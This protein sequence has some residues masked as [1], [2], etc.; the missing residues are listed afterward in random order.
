MGEISLCVTVSKATM[1][2]LKLTSM[3]VSI[4]GALSHA[5][6][7]LQKYLNTDSCTYL[8]LIPSSTYHICNFGDK[9][10]KLLP[11]SEFLELSKFWWL[12]KSYELP[13]SLPGECLH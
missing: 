11:L 9:A 7:K 5:Y 12:L 10:V 4:P 2:L 13:S 8:A 1:S 3:W 6:K